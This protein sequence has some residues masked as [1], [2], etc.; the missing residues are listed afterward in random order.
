MALGL[1]CGVFT[2][3]AT[4][5]V[6]YLLII[7]FMST[8]NP[9][10]E[11]FSSH[12]KGWISIGGP[13]IFSTFAFI[14]SCG[15]Y[16]Y[17]SIRKVQIPLYILF[18]GIIVVIFLILVAVWQPGYQVFVDQPTESIIKREIQLLPPGVTEQSIL[19]GE[20]DAVTGRFHSGTSDSRVEYQYIL[21]LLTRDGYQTELWRSIWY[22]T[23]TIP[24]KAF[25][26]A[27]T[28]AEASGARVELQK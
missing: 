3:C 24:Q 6:I 28:I 9:T 10:A 1:F 15:A 20:V 13:I 4:T 8:P 2:L 16:V 7:S 22:G 12:G 14:F 17:R 18:P 11:L 19:F 26:L 27:D 23:R 5:E 21:R 25:S